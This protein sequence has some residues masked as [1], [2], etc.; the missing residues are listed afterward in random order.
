MFRDRVDEELVRI[1]DAEF[2]EGESWVGSCETCC[3]ASVSVAAANAVVTARM[4]AAI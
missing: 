3:P 1:L 4:R 2:P